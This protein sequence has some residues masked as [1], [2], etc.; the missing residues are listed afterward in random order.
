MQQL[1]TNYLLE[2]WLVEFTYIEQTFKF[3]FIENKAPY[4]KLLLYSLGIFFTETLYTFRSKQKSRTKSRDRATNRAFIGRDT[5]Q[6]TRE[7]FQFQGKQNKNN[8]NEWFL[9]SYRSRLLLI[10]NHLLPRTD[11]PIKR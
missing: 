2:R 11:S 8:K 4:K 5:T 9:R 10:E 6:D 3:Y 7:I 1:P